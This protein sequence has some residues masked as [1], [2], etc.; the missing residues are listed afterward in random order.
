MRPQII[1][2]AVGALIAI[3]VFFGLIAWWIADETDVPSGYVAVHIGDGPFED[4]KP[5]GCVPSGTHDNSP[6]NDKYALIPTSERD[7]D[8]TGQDGS[9]R[10]PY[11]AISSDNIEMD[12][13]VTVRFTIITPTSTDD[14][15][16]CK[17][18]TDFFFKYL[19]RY[20]AKFGAGGEYND[21]WLV[22]LRKLIGD[23]TDAVL[24]RMLKDY[25]GRDVWTDPEVRA[26]IEQRLSDP[27]TGIPH[28]MSVAAKG[29]YFEGITVIVGSPNPTNTALRDA[30]A[31]EQIRLA[32]I[33]TERAQA[34]AEA[35]KQQAQARADAET[36][37]AQL[38]VARAEAAKRIAEIRG[39]G[40]PA[41]YLRYLCITEQPNCN[42]YQPTYVAGLPQAQ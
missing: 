29:V 10:S 1:V 24:D 7:Y 27:E 38:R 22:V 36:A 8:A 37:E 15:E 20:G 32:E 21:E 39:Y 13:P 11:T 18:L 40:G 23:P 12:V 17:T 35:E 33:R 42:P 4:K 41:N 9:D 14:E 26:E 19:D 30:A 6:T 31:N 28:L 34:L 3:I 5:K 2:R 25:E 16:G